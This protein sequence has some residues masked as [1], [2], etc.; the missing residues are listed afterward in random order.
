MNMYE[1]TLRSDDGLRKITTSADSQEQAI[2]QVCDAE[3]APESAVIKVIGVSKEFDNAVK[4][5]L[6]DSINYGFRVTRKN[7]LANPI[8]HDYRYTQKDC[9]DAKIE[10]LM[11]VLVNTIMEKTKLKEE[12]KD[13]KDEL[14]RVKKQK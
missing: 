10:Y 5:N 8:L 13:I 6:I 14:K 7:A 1:L 11:D 4:S 3:H 2:K 12:L 9:K